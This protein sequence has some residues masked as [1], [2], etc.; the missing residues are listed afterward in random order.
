MS[1][2]FVSDGQST[3][4]AAS[5]LA[6]RAQGWFLHGSVYVSMLLSQPVPFPFPTVSTRPF[7]TSAFL[8]L[9]GRLLMRKPRA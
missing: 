9:K 1:W 7:S 4:A 5:A 2:L 8:F 6:M 3:G